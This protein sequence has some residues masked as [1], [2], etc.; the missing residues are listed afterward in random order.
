[1][2]ADG[3]EPVDTQDDGELSSDLI[4]PMGGWEVH[5]ERLEQLLRLGRCAT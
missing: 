3:P 5:K 1:M 4:R 2:T